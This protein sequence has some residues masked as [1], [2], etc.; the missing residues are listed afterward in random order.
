MNKYYCHCCA[1]KN[2]HLSPIRVDTLLESNYQLEKYIKHTCPS[3]K[4]IIQSVFS[5]PSTSSY[6]DYIVNAGFAGSVEIDIYNRTNII[7][8]AGESIGFNF[9]NGVPVHPENVVKVVLSTDE[10]RIHAF[11]QSSTKFLSAKCI[12]CGCNI[13]Y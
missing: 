12:L 3:T 2:I 4:E 9:K 1:A 11:S 13:I 7:W 10:N 8:V 5:N 6:A